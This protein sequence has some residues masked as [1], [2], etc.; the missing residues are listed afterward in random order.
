MHILPALPRLGSDMIKYGYPS[1]NSLPGFFTEEQSD[2]RY[3]EEFSKSYLRSA[4]SLSLSDIPIDNKSWGEG[5]EAG[6]W[7]MLSVTDT[8]DRSTDDD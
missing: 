8:M 2:K 6:C 7:M 3:V 4:L 5:D 1:S